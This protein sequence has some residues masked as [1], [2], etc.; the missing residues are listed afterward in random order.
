MAS[1]NVKRALLGFVA[2][3][4]QA[5]ANRIESDRI[6]AANA[7][8]E[9]RL[10]AI[11]AEERREDREFARDQEG[12]RT[13]ITLMGEERRDTLARDEM[14]QRR[15]LQ[16]DELAARERLAREQAAAQRDIAALPA[17]TAPRQQLFTT[18]DGRQVYVN[19]GD[20]AALEALGTGAR[21]TN[22]AAEASIVNT[23]ARLNAQTP[24]PG[25][26]GYGVTAPRPDYSN[27][28]IVSPTSGGAGAVR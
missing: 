26:A 5:L 17:R 9:E 20:N 8:R 25:A 28:S 21:P 24:A 15:E 13:K 4:G 23:D 16:A 3:G 6:A 14:A 19:E 12:V 11:R 22:P 27:W 18:A 10:A 7:A 1:K 2:A